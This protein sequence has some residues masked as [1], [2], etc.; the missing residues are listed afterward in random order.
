M[1]SKLFYSEIESKIVSNLQNAK[2]NVKIAVAWFTNPTLFNLLE[3]LIDND[4]QIEL[5]LSDEKLNFTNE[6]VNFQKLIDKNVTLKISTFP[7]LMHN[8]FCIIDKRILISGSY[9]WTLKAEKS[10]YE[11]I[12]ISTDEKLVDDFVNYFEF[13]QNNLETV[14][15]ISKIKLNEYYE[16]KELDIEIELIRNEKDSNLKIEKSEITNVYDDNLNQAIDKADLLYLNGELKESIAFI[17][18]QL[19][20]HQNIPEF[21]QILALCNWRLKDF[22]K[23]ITFSQKV[24]ELENDTELSLYAYNLLGI[25]Y[26]LKKGGEQQ[27]I[28]YYK[29]CIDKKPY[30]H[31]FYRNRAI[32]Y[33][34]LELLP[35]LPIKIR[36]NY[37]Q[38]ADE[39]L[40]KIIE[41]SKN[42]ESKD[43]QLLHSEA[44]AHNLL[45]NQKLALSLVKKSLEAFSLEEN[46]FKKDKNELK[47]IKFLQKEISKFVK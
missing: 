36:N 26:S 11:N 32:S 39:D 8:K 12:I 20:K 25:G 47:E 46:I 14:S 7:N 24:I 45:G 9:N 30:E 23:Q 28:F 41:I 38:K 42:S 4:I 29:K 44:L 15:N 43:Y 22:E 35:N 10:N 31:S 34:N 19:K 2:K 13:L 18:E 17:E 27:S 6:K 16:E 33:I 1:K 40:K 21:Y 5:I 3:N 37:K